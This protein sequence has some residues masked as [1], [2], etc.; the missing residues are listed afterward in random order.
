MDRSTTT[1][2]LLLVPALLLLVA[3]CGG[4]E[5]SGDGPD[6]AT[7]LTRERV[8]HWFSKDQLETARETLAPLVQG[9]DADSGDLLRAAAIE[10]GLSEPAAA[11]AFLARA[12]ARD[13]E[14]PALWFLRGQLAREG[15]DF[16]AAVR[17]LRRA[18]ELAPGD[19][20]TRYVLGRVLDDLDRT[21]EAEAFLR[22]VVEV[23]IENGGSWYVSSLYGLERLL[24]LDGREDEA[25]VLR[26]RREELK[27]AGVGEL[28]AS[29]SRVGT[30]GRIAPPEPRGSRVPA[31]PQSL[32][33]EPAALELPLFT[34][35]EELRAHDLDGDGR[36]DLLARTQ[37][38]VVAALHRSGGWREQRI[39]DRRADRVVALDLDNEPDAA[40]E[41]LVV[42]GAEVTAHR[43]DLDLTWGPIEV[44]TPALPGPPAALVPVDFDHEGD[45]DLL[46]VGGFGARLW[47]N[48]GA[49]RPEVEARGA[50][51]DASEVAGLP[52]DLSLS[53][54]TVEDLDG[55]NDVDLLL[56]GPGGTV[57]MDSLRAGRFA[58]VSSRFP[59]GPLAEAPLVAD[60]DG[61]GRP[62]LLAAGAGSRLWLQG[63]D[64]SFGPARALPDL[65]R[66]V[67]AV[68]LDL[69]GSLDVLHASGALL[70]VGLG[71]QAP[72]ALEG[73]GPCGFPRAVLDLDGDGGPDL[74]QIDGSGGVEA[75]RAAGPRGN[76]MP[77]LVRGNKSNKRGL[78][79]IVEVRAGAIYR[80][81]YYR[82]EPVR[83]GVGPAE[84]LD[85]L[86]ITYPNGSV[87]SR[88]DVPLSGEQ[89]IDDPDAAFGEF[90]EPDSLIGSCPFLYTWNGETFEFVTDVLGITPLGLPMA[91]GMMVPPDH[92]EYVLVTGEQL[93][94]EDG[95]YR[96]QVTEELREVT[97]LDRAKL[98]VV[99]HPEEAEVYPNELFSFPPFP[100][101]H[102]HTVVD[103]SPVVRATGSDGEDWT[104]ALAAVDDAHAIPFERELPQFQGLA[105]P[106]FL[107]LEFDPAAVR[108]AEG[109]RLV[110]TGW[111]FWSDA[112]V[113]M[114]AARTPGVDFVPPILQVP[115]G[116][117]GWRDA[118]PPV[119]FPAGKTK[120]M[121]VDVAGLLDPE[122]PRLRIFCTL[123]LHWDRI[124]LATCGD[125]AERTLTEVEATSA[126]LRPRG[127]S[128]P[129]LTHDPGLPERFE[130]DRVTT[131]PRWDPHPGRYTRFG[132]V[133]PLLE[134]V[135]DRYVVMGT[136]EAIELVF[137]AGGVPALP[138][139]WRRDYLLFL[140]GWAK[141]RDHNTLEAETVE[142]LPFHGMSGYPYGPDEGFPDE[143]THRR[144]REEWQ[145]REARPL[146]QPLAPGR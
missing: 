127:F 54:A 134:E 20:P 17:H 50:F 76:S 101:A 112:S 84:N 19:L 119:G 91:P 133:L 26:A 10:F 138:A 94:E 73:V 75:L 78:G 55:D 7:T 118:G 28:D 46:V 38:G 96:M 36:L 103:P 92:D 108:A 2:A 81:V 11:E 107:E 120:T 115:D 125:D 79:S 111:F 88:L 87:L 82:G 22:G 135:D 14:D 4:G 102:L 64:L 3:S 25:Q 66:P 56:G 68:D 23:G 146:I 45:V 95:L 32:A 80:R 130:W 12:E 140:D 128:A 30:F 136:G 41:L 59:G 69:D 145:T 72:A 123:Q 49:Y 18:N 142:P 74:V 40:L 67:A 21:E 117:G 52:A 60:V 100:E 24:L 9:G 143:E 124:A 5:G 61:D 104:A 1:N 86:R 109:L 90:S 116:E 57:L 71:V 106:W 62:D 6:P 121:L 144:W 93:V 53:W 85:V 34:D 31:P 43:L 70:A 77:V 114:L 132:E 47:R 58:D 131:Q 27:R 122:D 113:N 137:P 35:L 65:P 39:S 83:V 44:T 141:D 129:V 42:R 48:D 105:K 8:A 15:G 97:Y 63:A 139:G 13:P 126:V 33:F 98:I 99:D 89:L 16:E 51:V 37:G 29:S 110:M